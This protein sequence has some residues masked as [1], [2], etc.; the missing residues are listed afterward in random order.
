[1]MISTLFWL[2]L[3]SSSPVPPPRE[4]LRPAEK[5]YWRVVSAQQIDLWLGTEEAWRLTMSSDCPAWPNKELQVQLVQGHIQAHQ[6]LLVG[7]K[8]SC[9]IR[10][11]RPIPANA[12]RQL[13]SLPARGLESGHGRSNNKR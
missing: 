6:P 1:M 7:L 3:G 10:D 9:I 12:N 4:Q 13:P 2:A 8:N 11:I 5:M